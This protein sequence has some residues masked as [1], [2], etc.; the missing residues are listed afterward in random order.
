M[1]ITLEFDLSSIVG[2][3]NATSILG[4][5]NA[6]GVELVIFTVTVIFALA[7]R[8]TNGRIH[9]RVGKLPKKVDDD[10]ARP[11]KAAKSVQQE[12]LR[13]AAQPQSRPQRD[14][15][16]NAAPDKD[17]SYL[18]DKIMTI[19]REQPSQ[20]SAQQAL[21]LYSELRG[22]LGFGRGEQTRP[23]SIADAMRKTKHTASVFYTTIVQCAVRSKQCFLVD[24]IILDMK[25]LSVP[26]SVAFYES[27]MKQLA[28]QKHYHLALS[29]YDH[30][31]ADGMH[32]SAVTCSC[33][34]G[35][36][37][38]VG[39][40]DRAIEFFNMLS[41]NSKPTIRAY[42]TVLRVHSKQQDWK[43]A[44][45]TLHDM[46][47][48]RVPVDS[49]ALNVVLATGIAADKMEEVEAVL[50]EADAADPPI[51]DVVSY[52][53]LVKGY[54]QRGDAQSA[55]RIR[56][57]MEAR[58]LKPNIITYNTL[59]DASV[60]SHKTCEA[61]LLLDEMRT[62]GL[63]PD[64]FTCSILVKG[65]SKR[66]SPDSIRNCA[67]LLQDAGHKCDK[68]LRCA[69]YEALLKVA[70]TS[71]DHVLIMQIE[72]EMRRENVPMTDSINKTLRERVSSRP[73]SQT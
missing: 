5:F 71:A 11:V 10:Y 56:D 58:G 38:E 44:S 36:A 25:A 59:M 70:S 8:A 17:A 40:H 14:M 57:R 15:S 28:G 50:T 47:T 53:T 21:Q 48:R 42:M 20:N 34:I 55:T 35:F 60:R 62:R 1:A 30:L 7:I 26:R 24:R 19:M 64:K 33:L 45:E 65:L 63:E 12:V 46:Q 32:P 51:S 27:A 16:F 37:A 13:P 52:N 23:R 18:I 3:F 49:L 73:S 22:C 68:S 31:H 54:A 67:K 69:L 29:C 41:A 39:E 61:W 66:T 9:Q 72:S 4:F 6:I 2:F 43:A